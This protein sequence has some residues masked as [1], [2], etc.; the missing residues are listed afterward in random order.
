MTTSQ[1]KHINGCLDG[2]GCAMP[3]NLMSM[4]IDQ[5]R[6]LFDEPEIEKEVEG[7]LQDLLD[8][9]SA[10]DKFILPGQVE[11]HTLTASGYVLRMKDGRV[12]NLS[13]TAIRVNG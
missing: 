12:F 2:P 3:T 9:T 4:Q 6:P 11:S 13:V 8:N 7:Y 5:E 10:C 1:L